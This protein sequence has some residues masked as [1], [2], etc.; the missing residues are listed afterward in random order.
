L[1][2]PFERKVMLPKELLEFICCP[3]C[4]KDLLYDKERNILTC[5]NCKVFYKVID[6]I[7]I[8]LE[9]EAISIKEIG[10]KN[11]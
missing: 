4:K 6:D 7:P 2:I 11:E 10:E 1:L 5:K 3:K 8:L 9:S